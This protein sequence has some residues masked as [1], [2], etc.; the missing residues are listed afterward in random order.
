M[1]ALLPRPILNTTIS[2]TDFTSFYWL[3]SELVDFCRENNL[4]VLG[5]KNEIMARIELFLRSGVK[6]LEK[7]KRIKHNSRFDWN[8]EKLTLDTVI[9]DNYKNT[10]NVRKFFIQNI[11]KEFAFNVKFMDFMKANIG[12]TLRDAGVEWKRLKRDR[13]P[14]KIASQFEYNAYIRDFLKDNPGKNLKDAIKFWKIKRNFPGKREYKK[15]D[16]DI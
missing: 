11:G 13:T 7:E 2:V 16:L 6:E 8:R 10:Q 14:Q 4:S 1:S 3:K 15:S 9:T 12:K 5:G